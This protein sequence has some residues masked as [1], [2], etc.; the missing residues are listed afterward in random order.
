MLCFSSIFIDCPNTIWNC[1]HLSAA[2]LRFTQINESLEKEATEW[3]TCCAVLVVLL[4]KRKF[5]FFAQI[6][7]TFPVRRRILP[8]QT[9]RV[10]GIRILSTQTFRAKKLR[11]YKGKW[12]LHWKHFRSARAFSVRNY[13][14]TWFF[15]IER[16]EWG[17][18]WWK[19]RFSSTIAHVWLGVFPKRWQSESDKTN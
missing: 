9:F 3:H 12:T 5:H 15:L 8:T 2:Q 13:L 10:V 18:S 6:G 4:G 11:N 1:S 19:L 17:R 7:G 14:E 16:H